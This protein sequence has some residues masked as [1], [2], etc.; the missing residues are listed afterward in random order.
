MRGT[1]ERWERESEGEASDLW[2]ASSLVPQPAHLQSTETCGQ[3][4]YNGIK[5]LE[6]RRWKDFNQKKHSKSDDDAV[7][8]CSFRKSAAP[9]E[10]RRNKVVQSAAS[11][12]VYKCSRTFNESKFLQKFLWVGQKGGKRQTAVTVAAFKKPWNVIKNHQQEVAA[13]QTAAKVSSAGVA[14]HWNVLN[15]GCRPGGSFLLNL[16]A[17]KCC[18][19]FPNISIPDWSRRAKFHLAGCCL[20]AASTSKWRPDWSFFLHFF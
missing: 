1:S 10:K 11:S 7:S 13:S 12:L 15:D 3:K 9:P 19:H 5:L 16:T 18:L 6:E 4:Y 2:L 17:S 14:E 20:G 8:Q